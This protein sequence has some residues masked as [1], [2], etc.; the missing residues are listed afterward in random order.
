M[1]TGKYEL[2]AKQNVSRATRSRFGIAKGIKRSAIKI[3]ESKN[4]WTTILFLVITE[5]VVCRCSVKNVFLKIFAILSGKQL[6][7]N[8][9]NDFRKKRI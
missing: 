3:N 1:P 7:K 5:A 6:S 9:K 8:K 4:G 2:Y